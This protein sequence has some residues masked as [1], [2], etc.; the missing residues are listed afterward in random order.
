[1]IADVVFD[2]P[3]D[4]PF[5]YLIPDSLVVTPGQR[6][7][8]PLGGRGT[9]VGVVVALRGA[10]DTAGLRPIQHAVEP[11]PILSAGALELGRWIADESLSSWGSTLLALL[12]PP[13]PPRSK[14]AEVLAPPLEPARGGAAPPPE[15]WMDVQRED[16]LA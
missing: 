6:V 16:R 4:H 9:R 3:L 2:L 7:S 15:V 12:P 8:A 5:S 13:P 11:A 1:M 14:R 10:S